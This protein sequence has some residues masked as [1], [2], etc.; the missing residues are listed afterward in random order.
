M[1]S[2]PDHIEVCCAAIHLINVTTSAFSDITI[3]VRSQNISG[4][5]VQQCSK[6]L[7][8]LFK[9]EG[10]SVGHRYKAYEV[11]ILIYESTSVVIKSLQ[12]TNI[13]YGVILFNTSNSYITDTA[14]MNCHE[15][16]VELII[17]NTSS[18]IN[19]V[20]SNNS[21]IC[22]VGLQSTNDVNLTNITAAYNENAGVFLVECENTNMINISAHNQNYGISL[23]NCDDTNMINISAAHNQKLGITL[24]QCNDTSM[25]NIS[26]AYNQ[27]YGIEL[28]QCNDTNMINISAHNQNYGIVFQN[29][30]DTSMINISAA[31]NQQSGITLQQC[32]DTSMIN[33][34][35]AYNQQNGIQLWQCN[36]TSMTNISAAYNQ[37]FGMV[38]QQCN[39][40]S[41]INI[42]A[43]SIIS[44]IVAGIQV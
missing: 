21:G 43:A 7:I 22:G 9:V 24:Y 8:Q 27:L 35:A 44:H 28:D 26:A 42:S 1:L 11:G 16:G 34:S 41:M 15:S 29:C 5:V 14:I 19:T 20:S 33:I 38:L 36:D 40:T 10:H 17:T 32:N 3:A 31:Y 2:V 37:N 25:I 4:V 23:L 6:I 39:D 30:N 12:V 18:I 13:S